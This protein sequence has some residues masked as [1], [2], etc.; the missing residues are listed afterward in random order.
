[1]YPGLPNL[2]CIVIIW[3]T[4][5]V[6][7]R[8]LQVAHVLYRHGIRAPVHIYPNDKY[9]AKD[10]PNGVEQLTQKGML[11]EHKLGQFLKKRYMSDSNFLNTSYLRSQVDVKSSD[12][13][14]CL[15]SAQCQLAGMYPPR[16]FQV[17]NKDI[18]WQPIPVHTTPR[19]NDT[20]IR[21]MDKCPRL[22]EIRKQRE[23]SVAYKAE[24]DKN[25]ELLQNVSF[26]AGMNLS[27][28]NLW[29]ITDCILSE[30]KEFNDVPAWSR[31]VWRPMMNL[32]DTIFANRWR[33]DDEMGRITGGP[34][35][36]HINDNMLRWSTNDIVRSDKYKSKVKKFN[37]FSG[38]DQTLLAL[39]CALNIPIEIPVFASSMLV[40]L[41]HS[42]EKNYWVEIYYRNDYKGTLK[43]LSIPNCEF[44]CPLSSFIELTKNRVSV[45]RAKECGLPPTD[46][47]KTLTPMNLKILLGVFIS[48]SLLLLTVIIILCYNRYSVKDGTFRYAHNVHDDG[49]DA[50]DIGPD[51]AN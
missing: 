35:L 36:A 25:M 12:V 32:S 44:K 20:L 41:Y 42:P 7:S 30:Q 18:A 38:H 1:M 19:P 27:F 10:W 23:N 15:Q 33:G 17:W 22:N 47:V 26:Y 34:L 9:Q 49:F 48:L 39:G 16:G 43:P 51:E 4:H 13:D 24:V 8:K 14:R 28:D 6:L 2:L 3:Q 29:W 21:P 40:E 45:D 46:E 37:L 5:G 50:L 31:K 11:L